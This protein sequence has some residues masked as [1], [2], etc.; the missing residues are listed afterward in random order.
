[1]ERRSLV[2]QQLIKGR[3]LASIAVDS[4]P[5]DPKIKHCNHLASISIFAGDT[6]QQT[7]RHVIVAVTAKVLTSNTPEI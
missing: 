5:P 1:M 7:I 3:Q 4:S 6:K 2:S